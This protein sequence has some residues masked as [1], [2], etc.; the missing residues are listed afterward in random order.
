MLSNMKSSIGNF[1]TGSGMHWP[2]F[3]KCV[4]VHSGDSNGF[5]F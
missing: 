5:Y 2:E 3:K 4:Y 1:V